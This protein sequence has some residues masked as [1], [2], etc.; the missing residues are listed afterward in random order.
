[1]KKFFAFLMITSVGV[2]RAHNND[3]AGQAIVA[4]AQ[5]GVQAYAAHKEHQ[6][7]LPTQKNFLKKLRW[8]FK[9]DPKFYKRKDGQDNLDYFI[10]ILPDQMASLEAKIAQEKVSPTLMRLKSN[11]MLNG[12]MTSILST[13]SGY[14]TY[15][16]FNSR[17]D[18]MV[19]AAIARNAGEAQ[20][21][22]E[23]GQYQ[24]NG[25]VVLGLTTVIFAGIAGKCFS[26]VWRYADRLAERLERDKEFLK[27]LEEEKALIEGRQL[28]ADPAL[29][30]LFNA[31]VDAV[32]AVVKGT[33]PP[34]EAAPVAVAPV[35]VEVAPVVVVA[36]QSVAV[37]AE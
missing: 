4:L 37:I 15:Y 10:A 30:N 11:A 32:N 33:L 12:V 28:T 3:D 2:A 22:T 16:V 23:L 8:M 14:A 19:A 1:M 21:L 17:R 24:M 7:S 25:S 5:V 6:D 9:N 35:A 18:T 27:I 20:V 29:T 36:E 13:L 31:L 34:A 26:K